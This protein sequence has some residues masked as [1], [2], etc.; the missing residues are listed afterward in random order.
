M[1]L[2]GRI[3]DFPEKSRAVPQFK[4]CDQVLKVNQIQMLDW[5]GNSSDLNLV[6][7]V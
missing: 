2:S 3:R 5:P 1:S 6:E 4:G 7:N